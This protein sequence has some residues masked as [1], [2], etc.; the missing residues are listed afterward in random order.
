VLLVR[1]IEERGRGGAKT[2]VAGVGGDADDLDGAVCDFAL[3]GLAERVT[4]WP[5]KISVVN[6]Y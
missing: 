3:E 2:G 6:E 4:N 1:K 5:K